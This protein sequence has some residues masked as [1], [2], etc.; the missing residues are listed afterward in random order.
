VDLKTQFF[1]RFY[2]DD[3]EVIIDRFLSAV[4]KGGESLRYYI[5]RFHKLSLLYPVGMPLPMLLQACRHNFLDKVKIRMG[6]VKAHTWKE[7]VRQAKIAE[8]STKKF[9]SSTFR[10]RA[11]NKGHARL[12]LLISILRQ[13]KYLGLRSTRGN[14]PSKISM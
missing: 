14:I 1:S 12:N 8:K 2:E 11:N 6:G 3:T 9:E 4:Q 10:W 7:L 13:W 5:E